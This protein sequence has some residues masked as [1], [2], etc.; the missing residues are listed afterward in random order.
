MIVQTHVSSS[1][2][3]VWVSKARKRR[4]LFLYFWTDTVEDVHLR[5]LLY[6]QHQPFPLLDLE[7][8]D[9]LHLELRHPLLLF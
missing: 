8:P 6:R 2:A 5:V 4:S 7:R 1:S 3:P 9:S